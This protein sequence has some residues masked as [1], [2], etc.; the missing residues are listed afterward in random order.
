V[1]FLPHLATHVFDCPL[2]I[3][4]AKFDAIMVAVGDRF[5]VELSLEQIEAAQ[6]F[7]PSTKEAFAIRDGVAIV[8]ITGSLMKKTGGLMAA[9][10][11]SSYEGIAAQL[12]EA[13]T[14]PSV[15]GILLDIDSPGGSTSGLFELCDFLGSLGTKSKSDGTNAKPIYAISNDAAFSAAYAIACCA[16]KLYVTQ[17]AGVGSIGV[18][19]AHV[20]QSGADVKAGLKYTFIH[21]GDKKVDGNSHEPL[22]ESALKDSQAEVDRIYG[23]FT[24]LV[25]R[26]RGVAEKAVV[27]TQ[28][29]TFFGENALPLLAD[30]VGT[31]ED[32]LADLQ[33]RINTN[34]AILN[35][36][37]GASLNN[38]REHIKGTDAHAG[39]VP[40]ELKAEEDETQM[41]KTLSIDEL[42]AKHA[43]EDMKHDEDN[44]NCACDACESKK[45]KKAEAEDD[46]EDDKKKKNEEDDEEAKK[47]AAVNGRAD[48]VRIVNLCTLAGMPAL[49]SDFLANSYTVAQVEKALLKH[50]AGKSKSV[51]IASSATKP[52]NQL[53]ATAAQIMKDKTLTNKADAYREYLME[54]PGEYLQTMLN[55]NNGQMSG[56]NYTFLKNRGF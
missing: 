24:K 38:R 25:A 3:H 44:E 21:A 7:K 15:K 16:D 45:A 8:P 1:T 14:N 13:Y 37:R 40:P 53:A 42:I 5:G 36:G 22:S 39:E 19:C 27:D 43:D 51:K 56:E 6:S 18:F 34:A 50:R 33:A 28:A 29:G 41:A 17:T 9:S 4:P 26:N 20:D 2:A 30:K 12:E 35:G 46:E 47:A 52:A 48:A 11:M 31:F 49:A 54:H 23:M 10:G 32:A 55:R